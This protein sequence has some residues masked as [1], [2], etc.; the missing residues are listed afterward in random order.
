MTEKSEVFENVIDAKASITE[1]MLNLDRK[2]KK[3]K[4]T[5]FGK[6]K[7]RTKQ[8]DNALSKLYKEKFQN[9]PNKAKTDDIDKAINKRILET[10]KEEFE[11]EVEK[12]L[13]MKKSKGRSSAIP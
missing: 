6:V 11:N 13:I 9:I 5:A 7:V 1:D 10:Q 4:F 8:A 12:S 3:I 2:L